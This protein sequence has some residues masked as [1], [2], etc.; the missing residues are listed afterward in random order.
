MN[1]AEA[2]RALLR[3]LEISREL[4]ALADDG[5][6]QAA[7]SLDA[8]RLQLLQ[9][10]RPALLPLHENERM[11]VREIAELNDR[12][13]GHLEHR[14]RAKGRDMDMLAVGR[15]ALRAYSNTRLQRSSRT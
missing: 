15:R 14:M 3:A 7:A 12:A 10:A 9:S 5:D 6:V 1:R 11:V 2:A 13:I 8:E 4:A